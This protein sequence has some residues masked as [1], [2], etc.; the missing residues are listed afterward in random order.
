[1]SQALS[2]SHKRSAFTLI[3]VVTSLSI[4]SILMI[5]L[6][7]A[8][9]I[10]SHAIPTTADAGLNDQAVIDG[11]NQFRNDLRE[12]TSIQYRVTA[13]KKQVVLQIKAAGAKGTPTSVGYSYTEST[14][15][16]KRQVDAQ[17]AVVLI[18][19]ISA[20]TVSISQD[21]PDARVVYLLMVVD[22][23]IQRIYEMHAALP[24][25]PEVI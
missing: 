11:M 19:G 10:G 23:T 13:D 5:G 6:S 2:V 3:E 20:F 4:L 22:D 9:L 15:T 1:M 24:D 12:A 16:F 21:G 14:G 17:S 7:S 25:T 8:V 18:S